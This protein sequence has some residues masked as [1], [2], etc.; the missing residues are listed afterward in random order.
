[1]SKVQRVSP[2]VEQAIAA[3]LNREDRGDTI[4]I[5]AT[6]KAARQAAPYLVASDE[7]L[8]EAIVEA[9]TAL[10]LSVAFDGRK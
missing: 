6:S 5:T 10:G 8:T 1:M 3:V 4:S 7:E 9:A 2:V